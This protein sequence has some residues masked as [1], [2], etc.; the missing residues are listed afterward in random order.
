VLSFVPAASPARR[1]RIL[2]AA[3]LTL[4]TVLA[5]AYLVHL[6]HQMSSQMEHDKMM[7]AMGMTMHM[8]WTAADTVFTF[9]MW[10]VMMIGMMAPAAAPVLLLFAGAQANR[11]ER[12]AP[13]AI[14][15]FGLGYATVWAG[16]SAAAALAQGA[17]HQAAML[18]PAMTTTNLRLGGAILALAGAYQMTPWKNKCLAHCRSPLGFLMA[19]WRDGGFGALRMGLR[20]GIYCLGCCWALMCILFVLGV[21][22]LVWVAALTGLVLLEKAGPQGVLAARAAGAALVVFGIVRIV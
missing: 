8:P 18:S 20:H 4:I 5:W 6:G 3:C 16:F 15:A 22:N 12:G 17:L 9:A 13:G 2:I 14:V 7:A 11:Q 19:N 10:V 21:M 1:D